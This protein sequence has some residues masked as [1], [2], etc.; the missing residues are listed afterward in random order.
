MILMET[1]VKAKAWGNSLGVILPADFVK[2]EDVKS[3]EELIISVKKKSNVL[4]ELFGALDFKE[5]TDKIIKN[6]RRDLESKWLD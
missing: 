5:P 1:R 6:V 2:A 4:K 3:G